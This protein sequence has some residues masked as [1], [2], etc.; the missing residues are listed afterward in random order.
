MGY[1]VK[2]LPDYGWDADIITINTCKDNNY[3]SLLGNNKIIRVNLKNNDT[4]VG[5]IEKI[6]RFANLKRH[7]RNNR[8]PFIKEVIS[9]FEKQD[10]SAILVSVSWELYILQAGIT[11]S[12]KWRIPLL[13]DL[14]DIIEQ[15][16]AQFISGRG[17]KAALDNFVIT[18]F[19]KMKINLRNNALK[20][21]AAITSVSPFHVKILS[22]FNP[23]VYL[24][25]NGYNP[26]SMGIISPE[27]SELFIIIYTGIV[28][29]EEEQDPSLLF[30]TIQKL[31]ENKVIDDN[32]L[33]VRF[34][35]PQI[36][37]PNII[38]NKYYNAIEKYIEF[39][40]YVDIKEIPGMLKR[41]SIGLVLANSSEG[42]GPQGVITTKL[43]DYVG[44]ER[45]VLCVRSDN[46]ILESIIKE[47]NIGIAANN[48]D[49]VYEYILE[50]WREWKEKG[51]TTTSIN[52]EFKKQF[53]RKSQ[54]RQF[55][56]ILEKAVS[57][58]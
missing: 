40:D 27:K 28:F 36:F 35:T 15:K 42:K 43:F 41:A 1:L 14:R 11:I 51:F 6:W 54:A 44:T 16:P 50:K 19:E 4:P 58:A 46:A 47:L 26:D 34:F 48:E 21:A 45:P 5:L 55:V 17:I 57:K 10:F 18:S 39:F 32:Q 23:N 52:H 12:Q 13:I 33:K 8:K 24:I 56:D 53:D 30:K 25:Y 29:R 31:D 20:H 49:E 9:N 2:Y 3:K 7:F 22:E 38:N 37:R